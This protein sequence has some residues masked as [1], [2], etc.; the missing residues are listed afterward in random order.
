MDSQIQEIYNTKVLMIIGLG[1]M[2]TIW[3]LSN[4]YRGY[5]LEAFSQILTGIMIISLA[6]GSTIQK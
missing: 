3:G 2:L 5:Y 6:T 4:F 1:A